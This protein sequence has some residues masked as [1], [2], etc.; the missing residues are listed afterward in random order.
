MKIL[1]LLLLLM[2]AALYAQTPVKPWVKV[3]GAP[4]KKAT[5]PP[6]ITRLPDRIP[7]H[8]HKPLDNAEEPGSGKNEG[9]LYRDLRKDKA[10][11]YALI[12]YRCRICGLW[13]TKKF[14]LDSFSVKKSIKLKPTK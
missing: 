2:P 13:Y 11:S 6:V 1:I 3:L 10:Y 12:D 4:K 8:T 14:V 7:R 5:K 9:K